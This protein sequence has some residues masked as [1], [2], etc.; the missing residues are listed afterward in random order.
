M[1]NWKTDLKIFVED[2][3]GQIHN[4]EKHDT[5]NNNCYLIGMLDAEDLLQNID[6]KYTGTVSPYTPSKEK[7][8]KQFFPEATSWVA[9]SFRNKNNEGDEKKS[10]FGY[11]T[12]E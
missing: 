5:K 7:Q 2:V 6:K 8:A 12:G 1:T 11:Q 4:A 9:N 10:V 3:K